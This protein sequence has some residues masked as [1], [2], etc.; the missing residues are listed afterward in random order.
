[1]STDKQS[2]DIEKY[3]GGFFSLL[4]CMTATI[5]D[6]DVYFKNTLLN[7]RARDEHHY[8]YYSNNCCTIPRYYYFE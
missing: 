1:M 2:K 7:V 5:V 3:V 8:T 6:Y 4:L